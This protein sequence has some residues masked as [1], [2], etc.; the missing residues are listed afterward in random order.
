MAT[1]GHTCLC[2]KK[3]WCTDRT[4][5]WDVIRQRWWKQVFKD[6]SREG[7]QLRPMNER[8]LMER[9]RKISPM[10][11]YWHNKG[12]RVEDLQAQRWV[13]LSFKVIFVRQFRSPVIRI[14][15]EWLFFFWVG[16]KFHAAWAKKVYTSLP[17]SFC[18]IDKD[19]LFI[20]TFLLLLR[21]PLNA[22]IAWLYT[23]QNGCVILV[24]TKSPFYSFQNVHCRN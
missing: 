23:N 20:S 21:D 24:S 3:L 12:L 1:V 17:S 10:V 2:L 19:L 8:S 13:V 7:H 18:F 11:M 6:S 9:A 14:F 16:Y 15:S 5:G 4:W 22:P